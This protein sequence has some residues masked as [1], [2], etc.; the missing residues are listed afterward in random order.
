MRELEQLRGIEPETLARTEMATWYHE[1]SLT[2]LCS[3]LVGANLAP[4][5][6]EAFAIL[7]Q[8]QIRTA[9]VSVTWEFAVGWFAKQFG[10]DDFVGTKLLPDGRI[11][12]FW[13]DDK[14]RWIADGTKRLGLE[15]DEVAAVGDSTGD[16]PMLRLV[17]HPYFVGATRP[18]ELDFVPH[19]PDGNPTRIAH[20]IVR[21]HQRVVQG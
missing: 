1:T 5:V 7:R 12:H 2:D 9:I 19:V 3:P 16:V 15:L 21:V 17:G 11:A 14:A 10:A 4:G 18:V 13:P 8:H 20:E 6:W